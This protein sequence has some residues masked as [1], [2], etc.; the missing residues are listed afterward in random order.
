[1]HEPNNSRSNSTEEPRWRKRLRKERAYLQEFEALS[2]HAW[3]ELLATRNVTSANHDTTL[4]IDWPHYCANATQACGG[5]EGWCYTFQG[6]QASWQHNRHSAMVDVLARSHPYLFAEHVAKEVR[7]AVHA[8]KIPYPNIR[9][10]GS[11]EMTDSHVPAIA[12]TID[13]GVHAWGFTRSLLIGEALRAAGAYV[14][15]SCDSTSPSDLARAAVDGGFPLA[16]SSN[17]V[18]DVPPP[19]T[20]VTFPVHRVGRVREV[21]DA[22]SLCPK[23]VSEFLHDE[24]P[25]GFCQLFC[26]RCHRGKE[27]Q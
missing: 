17:G 9:I 22:P 14:I 15:I 21:V 20:L 13:L 26:H 8:D 3:A 16:Y 11:G 27:N 25:A 24:R 1:M 10:S 6:R 4:S 18:D 23:V 2:V 5:P 19:G 12:R 7:R